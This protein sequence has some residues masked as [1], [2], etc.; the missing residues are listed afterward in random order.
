MWGFFILI[1]FWTT[2]SASI[3]Y[4]LFKTNLDQ[5]QAH[6]DF[7]METKC[8]FLSFVK[9]LHSNFINAPI[10]DEKLLYILTSTD[11]SKKK[12]NVWNRWC[13]KCSYWLHS[14][15]SV[16]QYWHTEIVTMMMC[17]KCRSDIFFFFHY[18]IF[19]YLSSSSLKIPTYLV[20]KKNPKMTKG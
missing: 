14:Q 2:S 6:I 9:V 10:L 12:K 16:F 15:V 18:K 1:K 3:K 19:K 5:N 11:I 13:W 7:I 20:L 17:F 8:G 4:I